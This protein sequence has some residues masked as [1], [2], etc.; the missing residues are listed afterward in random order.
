MIPTDP[1][2]SSSE[3]MRHAMVLSQL[4]PNAVT[5]P[6]VLAA[7]AVVPREAYLPAAVGE[8]AYR[9]AAVPIVHGRVQNPPLTTARLLDAARLRPSDRVLLIGAA[10]GYTAALLSQMVAEVVAVESDPAL[11]AIARDALRSG[12]ELVEGPLEAGHLEG[13]PYDVLVIDGAVEQVPEALWQQLKPEGRAV[14]GLVD[15][16]VIRLA[17]GRRSEHG[18]ALEPFADMEC[19]V[20]PGFAKARSFS[21]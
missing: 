18:F 3:A 6:R 10:G 7:M 1:A 19:A 5:D 21:F 13:A 15:R 12:I 8:L 16:G 20:L 2:S 11:L 17:A 9:E 14:S 4:R